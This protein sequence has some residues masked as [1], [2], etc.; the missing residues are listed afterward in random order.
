MVLGGENDLLW[1]EM[2][3]MH[4]TVSENHKTLLP[5]LFAKG[6]TGLLKCSEYIKCII[7]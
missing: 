7:M 2:L 3:E 6:L 1:S 4:E 5:K